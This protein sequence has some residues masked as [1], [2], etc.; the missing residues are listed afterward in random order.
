MRV[1]IVSPY[2]FDVAGGVQFHIRD[3]AETL[4]ARGHEVSV[5]APGDA[6]AD[7]PSYVVGAG[8]SVAVR[9]NG[10]IARLAFGPR[11][12]ARVRRWLNK[13]RFDVIH[14]HEPLSPSLSCLAVLASGDTPV[15]ATFHT[16]LTRSR[17]LAAGK[18]LAQLVLERVSA[19]IAVSPLARKVQVEHLGGGATEIPNGVD[20]GYFREAEPL[21]E[22]GPG[23]TI[24]FVGRFEEP[25]KGFPLLAEAFNTVVTEVPTARL[26]VVGPG[27]AEAVRRYLNPQAA[28]QVTFMGAVDNDTKAAMLSA[29]DVY[30]APNTGGESFG[31]ILTEAMS[32]GATVLAS[33]IPAF[34]SVLDGGRAGRLFRS[35]DVVD[36]ASNLVDLLKAPDI[37]LRYRTEADAWVQRY[38]WSTVAARVSEVYRA[39]IEAQAVPQS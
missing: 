29:L 16:A 14:V 7:L 30:V 17:V 24:G 22:A 38:D 1:G 18:Y 33:D 5:L 34:S 36:L 21:A 11:S 9:Y 35:E 4:M 19:R 2:S 28:E 25:R 10:S 20:V 23:P 15:V 32:A 3:L 39:A 31:M 8:R 27:E 6:N 26:L 12:A 37:R 13:G